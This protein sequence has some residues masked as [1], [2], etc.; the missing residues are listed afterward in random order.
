V[1]IPAKKCNQDWNFQNHGDDWECDCSEGKEQS[2]IDLPKKEIALDTKDSPLFKYSEV[3]PIEVISLEDGKVRDTDILKIKLGE[4]AL[5]IKA[6]FGKAVTPDGS[7]YDAE[8]LIIHTPSEHKIDGKA[9]DMEI[10]IVHNGKSVG[11]IGRQLTLAFLFEKKPGVYNKFIDDLDFFNL[12]NPTSRVVDIVNKLHISKIFYNSDETGE[13]KM[14]PF[15][16]YTYQGSLTA[17]PCSEDSIVYVASKPIELGSTALH[18]FQE[19]LRIPDQ[20]NE[21]GDITVSDWIPM[22]NRNIQPINGRPVFHFNH[23]SVCGPDK[24]KNSNSDSFGGD[25]NGHFERVKKI[26]DKYFF[27]PGKL[28]SGVPNSF[29]VSKNEAFGISS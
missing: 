12:P 4:N 13:P 25:G 1:P 27:V 16:F 20:I 6:K 15:S 24:P 7:V 21:N 2:P 8:E 28:A 17:P 18:M 14:K 11:D 23:E 19:S 29:V 22:S 9:Y 3:N 26:N 5:R 10:Q